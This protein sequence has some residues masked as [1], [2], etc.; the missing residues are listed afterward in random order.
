MKRQYIKPET[1]VVTLN[2]HVPLLA[3]SGDAPVTI[4]LSDDSIIPGGDIPGIDLGGGWNW[5][6]GGI[7]SE[8]PD[9]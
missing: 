2:Q 9:R 6:S 8:L 5:G 4:N 3:G 7:G 1:S